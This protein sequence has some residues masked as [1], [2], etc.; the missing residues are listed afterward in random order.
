MPKYSIKVC[1]S[2]K[3]PLISLYIHRKT[4]NVALTYWSMRK[5]T[6]KYNMKARNRVCIIQ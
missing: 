2:L 1:K 5:H 3:P 6:W 4:E